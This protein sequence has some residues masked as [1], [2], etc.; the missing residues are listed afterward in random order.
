MLV[1]IV[2]KQ[3]PSLLKC[4]VSDANPLLLLHELGKPLY[5][6]WQLLRST[7]KRNKA[8]VVSV[9]GQRCFLYWPHPSH[10]YFL[11][12]N[13]DKPMPGWPQQYWL[14][15]SIGPFAIFLFPTL[16]VTMTERKKCSL[17]IYADEKGTEQYTQWI[18][19]ENKTR[20][21]SID[22]KG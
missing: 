16:T 20:K 13:R 14:Q 6:L 10:P 22:R 17:G 9:A 8:P 5:H 15:R 18:K 19:V 11:L 4:H 2:Y 21:Q 1:Y 12:K 3:I 7:L